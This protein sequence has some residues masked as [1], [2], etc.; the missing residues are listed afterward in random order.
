MTHFATADDLEDDGFFD[1]QLSAFTRW[2]RD[3]PGEPPGLLVH[4][5]NSAAMLREPGRAVRHG[6]L[7]HRRLRHG[8]VRQRPRGR[9]ARAGAR[10]ELLRRRGQALPG[11]ARAPATAGGSS[12]SATPRSACC[13]IGYGDGWRRGLSNNADVLIGG[14]RRHPLVGTVS[15]DSITVDLGPSGD[16]EPD[17]SSAPILIGLQGSERITAEEV[18][19]RLDTINYEVTCGLTPRVPR[20]YHRDGAPCHAVPTAGGAG[21]RAAARHE[22]WPAGRPQGAGGRRGLAGRRR[23]SRRAARPG[24]R[25]TSTWSSR[26]TPPRPHAPWP[27][28]AG[29]AACFALSED[30]GAWRV[31]ARDGSWQ[32]DVEPLRGGTLAGGPVAARLHGQRD[33]PADRRR[34]ADRSRSAAPP[35]CAPDGCGW[36]AR[37]PSRSTRCE[38]C[39]W[40]GSRSSSGSSPTSRPCAQPSSTRAGCRRVSGERIFIELRRIIAAPGGRAGIEL[41]GGAGGAGASCCPSWRRCAASSRAAYHHPDVYDHTL[42]VLDRTVELTGAEG[43]DC[44]DAAPAIGPHREAIAALLAEPLADELTRGEALRWGALLHDAAKPATREVRAGRPRDVHRTRPPAGPSW[45]GRCSRGCAPASAC[46]RTWRRSF[47]TTCVSASSSTSPSRWPGGPSIAYL[48]AC[49][50]VEVDVTLLSVAD[51]LATRGDRAEQAIAAHLRLAGA[52]LGDAL[53]WRAEGPPRPLVRGDVLAR[54]LG[55]PEGPL[56]GELLEGIREASFAGEVSTPEQAVEH[57]RSLLAADQAAR[58]GR[59]TLDVGSTPD[60]RSRLHLLQDR[61][62]RAAGPDRRGG[63]AH[64]RLHGHRAGEPRARTGDP[65]C[66]PPRPDRHRRRGSAGDARSPRSGWPDGCGSGSGPTA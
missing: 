51:R 22:R 30:F 11:R 48:R 36:P 24:R 3:D 13:P 49:S 41:M 64:D 37:P 25:P 60:G 45:R 9:G 40:C 17:R 21:R 5:A 6:A 10:A 56:L 20:V 27:A 38:C 12:P 28:A 39:A 29:R 63:R 46:G 33:R 53:S 1:Q 4:A 16:G 47:A 35:T 50:P 8:P 57:A 19:R 52:M 54:R 43:P 44:P 7:R 23:G 61:R 14:E 32:V 59:R 31:V 62:R 18:A 42:E 55:I 65:A 58:A 15:M 66:P 26:A 34:S 2:A